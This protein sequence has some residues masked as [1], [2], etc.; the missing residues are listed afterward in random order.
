M[1]E[2]TRRF[3]K[4]SLALGAAM[5]VGA[6]LLTGSYV[7]A[8]GGA[9]GTFIP[10]GDDRFET[11]DN[12]E[13]YHNFAAKPIP[14]G[15]FNTDGLSTSAAYSGTVPVKGVPLPG[16]GDVDTII[17]R[18]Q[19]VT[20]PGTTTL[21]MIGLSLVSINPITV[22][23]SDRPSELWSV[24]VGLSSL[25]ASTGTMTIHDGGTFD[26]SLGVFPKF[27]FTR[28]SDGAVKTL[29]TGSGSGFA[30]TAESGEKS[31]VA[32]PAPCHAEPVPVEPVD[33]ADIEAEQA[34]TQVASAAAGSCAPVRL[35]TTN[36]PWGN[37]GGRFCIPRPITEQE[38]WASHNASPPGT[39]R[40][41]ATTAG[42]A[43]GR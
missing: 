5:L 39:I 29:D 43:A 12:G 18:N 30:E 28:L 32:Q 4:K 34:D 6:V 42:T 25:Q 14:A 3:Y 13:S 8:G 7:S 19:A 11:T 37:C 22:S 40:Q 15:F 1:K 35:T 27:T 16:Q 41:T 20:T 26:S 21:Q 17:R 24:R 10:A 23:Y 2:L 36:S 9:A 33:R 38:L 31:A